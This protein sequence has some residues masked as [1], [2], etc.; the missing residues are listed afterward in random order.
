MQSQSASWGDFASARYGAPAAMFTLGIALHAFNA[1]IVSTTMPSAALEFEAVA[2]LSWATSAYL[3]ASIVGGAAAA[4]L[5]ARFG[6]RAVLMAASATF[7]AGTLSFGLAQDAGFLIAGRL[8][9]G[10]GGG[11]VMASCYMLIPEIFPKAL[12]PR[13]FA[14]ESV[15]WVLAA[16]GGPAIA[17]VVTEMSSWRTAVLMSVPASLAFVAFI[18]FCVAAHEHSD[19]ANG[20]LPL[21]Q[22]ALVALGVLLLSVTSAFAVAAG[23][24]LIGAAVALDARSKVRLLPG[25]AFD[26]SSPVS[27]GLLVIFLMCLAEASTIVYVA[28]VGQVLWSLSV[29]ESGFLAAVVAITWSLTAIGVAHMPRL[30]TWMHVVPAPLLL[31]LGLGLFVVALVGGSIVVAVASQILIGG[32]FGF[33]W[34]RLC[35][36]I[37]E[38]APD[39]ERDFAAG[40]I[41]TIQ[42]A[43]LS[44][45]AALW[46]TAA[47]WFGLEAHQAAVGVVTALVPVFAAAALLAL[48]ATP[49]ARR[50]A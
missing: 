47:A 17:G 38:V 5:K 31:A 20:A 37:M 24:V 46:G 41:P 40:A 50:A 4:T 11:V 30:A 29:V 7:M 36:H 3:V 28:F 10:G 8:L 16:I 45:G 33:S 15:A 9:Q 23:L 2:L 49:V 19:S 25:A 48:A 21:R 13:I 26:A 42:F 22:L 1:F 27:A 35:E 39:H 34:A 44:I 43:G 6:S 12:V 14:L 18:P 32:S